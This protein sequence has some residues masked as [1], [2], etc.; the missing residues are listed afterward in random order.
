[1]KKSQLIKIIHE[2]IKFHEAEG[3]KENEGDSK[4]TKYLDDLK[5]FTDTISSSIA[6]LGD[7]TDAIENKDDVTNSDKMNNVNKEQVNN[8]LT[9]IR[10]NIKGLITTYKEF[11]KYKDQKFK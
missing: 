6:S 9:S 1:M 2:E 7:N 11:I 5:E 10:V 3:K 8:L 4:L